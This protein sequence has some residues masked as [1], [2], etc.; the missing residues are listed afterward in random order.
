MD[1]RGRAVRLRLLR[2]L[3]HW[4]L[5]SCVSMNTKQPSTIFKVWSRVR[6][7]LS[8]PPRGFPARQ[9]TTG[10]SQR[11]PRHFPHTDP[12]LNRRIDDQAFRTETANG[13]VLLAAKSRIGSLTCGQI[14][15]AA[16]RPSISAAAF[17]NR[18][19]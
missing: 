2:L 19:R 6:R 18:G 9:E 12:M 10:L 3:R 8:L 13:K 11:R 17:G 1:T 16:L 5:A 4:A 15:D 14:I 7:G